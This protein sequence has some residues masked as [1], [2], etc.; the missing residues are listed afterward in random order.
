MRL[1]RAVIRI[2]TEYH[3]SHRWQGCV[4]EGIEYFIRCGIDLL[5]RR[6]LLLQKVTQTDHIIII[7]L[8]SQMS[9][10]GRFKL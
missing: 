8:G 6:A 3:N 1:A 7:E 4:R 10:P 2:L 5:S 9:Q